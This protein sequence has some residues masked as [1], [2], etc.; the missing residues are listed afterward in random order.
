MAYPTTADRLFNLPDAAGGQTSEWL[1]YLVAMPAGSVAG[2]PADRKTSL[3]DLFSIID[4]NITDRALRFDGIASA[5]TGIAGQGLIYFDPVTGKFNFQNGINPPIAI[6]PGGTDTN[7][8]YNDAGAFG[9]EAG[10]TWNETTKTLSI[11]V[12]STTSGKITLRASGAS[13]TQTFQ[14]ADAPAASLTF[15]WPAASPTAN[16]LL[17]AAAPSG[18]VVSLSWQT[19]AGATVPGN[20]TNVIFNN[21]GNFDGENALS[22]DF[23]N[24]RLGV[25]VGTAPAATLDVKAA[26]L[27]NLFQFTDSTAVNTF[28]GAIGATSASIGTAGAFPLILTANSVSRVYLDAGGAVQVGDITGV[29]AAWLHVRSVNDTLPG[30]IVDSPAAA[31]SDLM[32]LRENTA[33]RFLF[34]P[35]ARLTIGEST[36]QAGSIRFLATG[37]SN[38]QEIRPAVVPAD[39]TSYLL[40]VNT[41]TAGQFLQALSVSL[42][43]IQLQW[44]T[45][46]AAA[47]GSAGMIQYNTSNL[48]DA[49]ADFTFTAASARVNLGV[50]STSTGTLRF[51]AAGNA[52]TTDFRAGSAPASSLVY[53]WPNAAP[54]AGQVLQA[55]APSGGVVALSWA[56]GGGNNLYGTINTIVPADFTAVNADVLDVVTQVENV[57]SV[58]PASGGLRLFE[59]NIIPAPY[60]IRTGFAQVVD[61]RNFAGGGIYLRDSATG[62]M[63]TLRT[64]I[65]SFEQNIN[66]TYWTDFNTFDSDA[67]QI[68]FQYPFFLMFFRIRD[69][70]TNLYYDVSVD[71]RTYFTI[72]QTVRNF[73]CTPDKMGF[74]CNRSSVNEGGNWSFYDWTQS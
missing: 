68:R 19:V 28:Y 64:A 29:P 20:S 22:W 74:Y 40:P 25:G 37:N 50:A 57:Y 54:S 31:A 24:D 1:A 48:L 7:I 8:Q 45:P 36:A 46:V 15:K 33:Q 65:F 35:D 23:L 56:S 18:G 4:L 62:K 30:L 72:Y 59:K 73:Y 27:G 32:Q 12:G 41:P 42:P 38:Y 6:A 49:S 34:S 14:S 3:N 21:A 47:A 71:G 2:N 61:L 63:V 17:A 55:A 13:T 11:G 16:Q 26:G 39:S 70:N 53:E 69:D 9:G 60:S 5:P 67:K 43:N 66:V 44:S 51:N 52:N 10:F 58:Q